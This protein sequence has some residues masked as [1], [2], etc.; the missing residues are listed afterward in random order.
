MPEWMDIEVSKLAD[1]P[2]RLSIYVQRQ[3]ASNF[4]S[5]EVKV[6]GLDIECCFNL[7]PV[8]SC[9]YRARKL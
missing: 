2:P 1:Y 9:E 5:P 4:I 3:N 6:K 8:I 7:V